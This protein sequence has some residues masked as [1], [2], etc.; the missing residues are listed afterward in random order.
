[1]YK[2]VVFGGLRL[3]G[4]DV[5]EKN[6]VESGKHGVVGDIIRSYEVMLVKSEKLKD[7]SLRERGATFIIWRE[8]STLE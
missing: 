1:M 6:L 2:N 5:S 8:S 7:F 4:V 3:V